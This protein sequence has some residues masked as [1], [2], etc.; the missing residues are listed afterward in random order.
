[1]SVGKSM[2]M[3]NNN[4]NKYN[5]INHNNNNNINGIKSPSNNNNNLMM[6]AGGGGK[7]VSNGF[8]IKYCSGSGRQFKIS[9]SSPDE[10]RLIEENCRG[11]SLQN[12]ENINIG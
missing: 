1:M 8:G 7:A 3:G 6:S 2:M 11:F 9:T 4:N 5:N 10:G 12:Q